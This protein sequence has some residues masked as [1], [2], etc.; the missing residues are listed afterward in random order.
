MIS[1]VYSMSDV[2]KGSL[3][4]KSTGLNCS[5]LLML[6]LED[7][8]DLLTDHQMLNAELGIIVDLGTKK[9]NNDRIYACV[10]LSRGFVGWAHIDAFKLI[11]HND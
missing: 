8:A 11:N 2:K 6:R 5:Q 1:R 7:D 4:Q 9:D 3:V 10:L